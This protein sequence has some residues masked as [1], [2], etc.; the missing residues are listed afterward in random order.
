MVCSGEITLETAQQEISGNWIAAY[1]KYF[2]TNVPV[3]K[4]YLRRR[5]QSGGY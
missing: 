3:S 5:R 2:D 4:Q 1:R